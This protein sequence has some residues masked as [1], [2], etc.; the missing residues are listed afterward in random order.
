[1]ADG[2]TMLRVKS[3]IESDPTR[4]YVVVSAPGKR[5]GGDIKV[6]D[7]LYE[8]YDNVVVSGETGAAFEKICER[9]RGIVSELKLDLDIDR[10]LAET[11]EAIVKE[12]SPDFCASRGE[13]L[14]GRVM[15]ALLDVPFIDA[16]DVVKFGPDGKLDNART[17]ALLAEALKEKLG[18]EVELQ[19]MALLKYNRPVPRHF[20]VDPL[21]GTTTASG[22]STIGKKIAKQEAALKAYEQRKAE[23]EAS[24]EAETP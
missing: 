5:F 15:A 6:T 23:A 20:I 2:I 11:G 7:L 1:M 18:E 13:Y 10:I 22:T 21:A 8:T 17:Y 12:A 14:S 16:R 3:I 19:M 24:G 4:R 9:F